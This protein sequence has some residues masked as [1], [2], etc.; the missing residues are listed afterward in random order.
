[1][2]VIMRDKKINEEAAAALA[3]S[4][5]FA[6][7]NVPI[8]YYGAIDFSL[9][10]ITH[11]IL[12]DLSADQEWQEHFNGELVAEELIKSGLPN[13]VN[14]I[15]LYISDVN[16][17]YTLR[18]FAYKLKRA[19]EEKGHANVSVRFI[20]NTES[21]YTLLVPPTQSP[22]NSWHIYGI[23]KNDTSIEI[24]DYNHLLTL[25]DKK[26][27]FKGNNLNTWLEQPAHGVTH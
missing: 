16:P 18:E 4:D 8:H 23:V 6:K 24:P 20:S 10:N 25:P 27:L 7:Q 15:D 14:M 11:L 22:E 9:K 3:Q 26:L 13:T 19:L 21:D 1:M 2:I 12:L 17:S 5:L